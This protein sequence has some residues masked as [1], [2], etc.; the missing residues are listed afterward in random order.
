MGL[1]KFKDGNPDETAS[2]QLLRNADPDGLSGRRAGVSERLRGAVT[3]PTLVVSATKGNWRGHPRHCC[4]R[5]SL[6]VRSFNSKSRCHG[7]AAMDRRRL[8][9]AGLDLPRPRV[10]R[11][12]EA[13]DFPPGLAARVP[14]ERRAEVRATITPSNSW[15]SRSS[16]CAAKT[17]RSAAFTTP[18]ATAPRACWMIP[19]AI[20]AA[21][22]PAPITPGPTALDG[23]L[24]A[25]P[26]REAFKGLDSARHGLAP[27]DQ[28]IYLG[29]MFVRFAPGL[30]SV[31][32]M[33]APYAHELAAYRMEELVPQGRVTFRPRKVNWKNVAD[34]YRDGLHINVA[35]PGLTRLFGRGYGIEAK[36]WIDKM[37]GRSAMSPRATG[38]SGSIRTCCHAWSIC[39]T[40]AS[41]CGPTSSCGRTSLSTS[42]RIR[43]TSCS[44]CRCRPPRRWCARLPTS[45]RIS[46][47]RCAPTRYLNWRINRRVSLEDKALIERVQAGMGS[48]SYTV[49]PLSDGE[50]CLRSFGRRMR[51]LIP[52]S[53]LHRAPPRAG[54][55]SVWQ[56][57]GCSHSAACERRA[58]RAR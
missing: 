8:Q 40:T 28:E 9:P 7:T 44:S 23:R 51:S 32:E 17:G 11:A 14:S 2:K 54:A 6:I 12:R 31:R 55:T 24:V 48:S 21:G 46:A 50:V 36:P 52:E 19:R 35:H 47:A 29:F 43:S 53:R 27:L 26:Q 3:S 34:N 5:H 39:R 25:I 37:W 18:A 22:S 4:E 41:G 15:A 20:A 13:D 33:A 38:P 10:L 56:R 30:P 1:G 16:S 58:L 49:G 45:I 42:I 57:H